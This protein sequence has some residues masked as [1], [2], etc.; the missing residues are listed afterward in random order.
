[1]A[2]T[3]TVAMTPAIAAQGVSV[4]AAVFTR[5][6]PGESMTPPSRA[7]AAEAIRNLQ[8]S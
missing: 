6:D 5:V 7:K 4:P 3:E 2:N 8:P 1:M